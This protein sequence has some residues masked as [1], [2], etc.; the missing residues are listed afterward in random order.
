MS[1]IPGASWS[2]P[3]RF[4]NWEENGEP[5][6]NPRRYGEHANLHTPIY[7][8]SG[9]NQGLWSCEEAMPST[10]PLSPSSENRLIE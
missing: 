8:N 7:L 1:F 6:E 9:S 4:E 3:Y 2:H 5:R 10:T